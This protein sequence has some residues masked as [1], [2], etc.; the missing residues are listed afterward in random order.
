MS[1]VEINSHGD[2]TGQIEIRARDQMWF[3]IVWVVFSFIG[4]I[5][6]V[7][8][9][10]TL[11]LVPL[12]FWSIWILALAICQLRGW[13]G[14]VW[15]RNGREIL[16][17]FPDCIDYRTVGGTVIDRTHRCIRRNLNEAPAVEVLRF[18]VGANGIPNRLRIK[19]AGGTLLVGRDLAR[20]DARLIQSTIREWTVLGDL[21]RG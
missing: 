20:E 14:I 12:L 15:S 1:R 9:L 5:R 16:R 21:R 2:G 8:E 11:R 6:P 4:L 18:G 7:I 13:I 19:V 10:A 17:I 3:W